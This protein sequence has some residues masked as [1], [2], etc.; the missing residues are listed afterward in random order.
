MKFSD[1]TADLK[2]AKIEG[3]PKLFKAMETAR[4]NVRKFLEN[5]GDKKSKEGMDLGAKLASA[6]VAYMESTLKRS[7]V[8]EAATNIRSF[9]AQ[10]KAFQKSIRELSTKYEDTFNDYVAYLEMY[11]LNKK[12]VPDNFIVD[13]KESADLIYDLRAQLGKFIQKIE[14]AKENLEEIMEG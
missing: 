9:I 1:Y 14:I 11:G 3:N 6:A 2:E 4:E 12:D 5:G 10:V 8:N 13:Y 7:K